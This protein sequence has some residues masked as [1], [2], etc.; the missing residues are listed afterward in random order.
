M[1][2]IYPDDFKL[3]VINDYYSSPLGVRTIAIKYSLPSKN[4]INNWEKQLITKGLL[5]EGSTKPIKAVA[6]SKDSLTRE[7]NRT[8]REVFYEEE[9]IRLQA[10]VDYLE[11]LEHLKPFVAKKKEKS[12]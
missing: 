1:K 3:E 11:T 4:Y 8:A 2:R 10:K 5:P 12:D 9:I 7:D 6:R